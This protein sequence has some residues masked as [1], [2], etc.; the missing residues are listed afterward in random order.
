M[1]G[2]WAAS[3]AGVALV[4]AFFFSWGWYFRGV[5]GRRRRRGGYVKPLASVTTRDGGRQIPATG[6]TARISSSR[7]PGRVSA[8]TAT[9]RALLPPSRPAARTWS[10]NATADPGGNGAPPLS[11]DYANYL[12]AYQ[13]QF[14]P[15][16]LGAS[17]PLSFKPW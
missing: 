15:T 8:A 17:T 7:L 10:G 9:Q 2:Q 3:W 5:Y 1:S 11:A 13:R 12:R 16:H 14:G 6:T 4:C